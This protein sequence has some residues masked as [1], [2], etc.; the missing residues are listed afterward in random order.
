MNLSQLRSNRNGD[1]GI[2]KS[3]IYQNKNFTKKRELKENFKS[4]PRFLV[5]ITVNGG[6]IF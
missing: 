3:S 2:K 5:C 4:T 6:A 1:K